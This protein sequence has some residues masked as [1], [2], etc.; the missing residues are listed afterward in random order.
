MLTSRE[1]DEIRCTCAARVRKL[2][3]EGLLPTKKGGRVLFVR[4]KDIDA[5]K[6]FKPG[7]PRKGE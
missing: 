6:D 2:I 3:I 5:V 7:R 4:F 1:A